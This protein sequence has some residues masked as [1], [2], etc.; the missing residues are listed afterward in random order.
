MLRGIR[1]TCDAEYREPPVE[2]E[3]PD[4]LQQVVSAGEFHDLDATV[5]AN[6]EGQTVQSKVDRSAIKFKYVSG[7]SV[8]L[9]PKFKESYK[10]EYTGEIL[11]HPQI[12]DAMVDE[13]R[14]VCEHVLEGVA[15]E[16]A[17]A[18]GDG[19]V[20]SGRWALCNK[21]DMANPK[22]RARYTAQEVHQE[23]DLCV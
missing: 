7:E 21:Q 23:P 10:D 4:V 15:T 12:C 19:K 1:D 2:E 13:M 3:L 20:S 16:D 18:A 14:Y 17:V 22:C 9:Q 8:N 5:F 6:L 11:P